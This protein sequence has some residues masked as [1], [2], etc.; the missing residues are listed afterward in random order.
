MIKKTRAIVTANE[1]RI[2]TGKK[3]TWEAEWN[4]LGQTGSFNSL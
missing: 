4:L 3:G 1:E 2:L